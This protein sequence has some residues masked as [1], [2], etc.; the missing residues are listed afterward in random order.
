MVAAFLQDDLAAELKKI[1]KGFRLK[2]PQGNLS[3]IHIF[4]QD[5]PMPEPLKQDGIPIE[6]LE[7][8]LADEITAKDPF[9][10]ILIRI[11]DGEIKDEASAQT[12]NTNLIIG[13]YDNSYDKQGHKDVL[14]IIADIYE[15]F[16]KMAVLGSRYTIQYPIIWTL[17]EE[18]SYPY[19]YGGMQLSW[20]AAAIRR[21]DKF[22]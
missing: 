4:E 11:E 19:Y 6:A 12:I 16:A 1:L 9:P 15:R 8:G 22:A 13:I 2:D 18:A 21:E 7:N 20:E 3:E 14:N 10:Y 17:Q 5:L